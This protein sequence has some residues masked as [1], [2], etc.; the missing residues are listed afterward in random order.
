M[1][2]SFLMATRLNDIDGTLDVISGQLENLMYG[3]E[4]CSWATV[5]GD[6]GS[7]IVLQ[8]VVR[9]Q[10][11]LDKYLHVDNSCDSASFVCRR[12]QNLIDSIRAQKGRDIDLYSPPLM[13]VHF[14]KGLD[15]CVRGAKLI[16]A[17]FG[18]SQDDE[19]PLRLLVDAQ[20][21]PSVVPDV[22]SWTKEVEAW[23]AVPQPVKRTPSRRSERVSIWSVLV[24]ASAVVLAAVLARRV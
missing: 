20:A 23:V 1:R 24:A 4:R 7:T 8:R 17:C 15:L 19:V 18:L 6:A 13:P 3:M 11:I 12:A 9:L 22:S 14:R 5:E 2:K 10:E 21:Q 16:K